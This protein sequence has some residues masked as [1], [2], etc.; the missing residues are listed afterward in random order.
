MWLLRTPHA[1]FFT[2]APLSFPFG[3]QFQLSALVDH[4][5]LPPQKP[6]WTRDGMLV[7]KEQALCSQEQRM[8]K[9]CASYRLAFP[10]QA[11]I[12]PCSDGPTAPPSTPAPVTGSVGIRQWQ[13]GYS[14]EEQGM[15]RV[16]GHSLSQ[17]CWVPVGFVALWRP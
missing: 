15:S 13:P 2:K 10:P 9:D 12:F 1:I 14:I 5:E 8:Q 6:L 17:C 16:C 4:F 3:P 11:A 7:F